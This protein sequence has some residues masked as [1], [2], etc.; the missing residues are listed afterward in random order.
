MSE[1]AWLE[2]LAKIASLDRLTIL[3]IVIYG[4]WKQWWVWGHQMRAMQSD[5]DFWRTAALRQTNLLEQAVDREGV[6]R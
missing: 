2:L 3:V 5:R 4:G 1:Q 6:P